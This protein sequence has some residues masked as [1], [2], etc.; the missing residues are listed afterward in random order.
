MT[1][2]GRRRLRFMDLRSM[3]PRAVQSA[4]LTALFSQQLPYVI[5]NFIFPSPASRVPDTVIKKDVQG[6]SYYECWL[7]MALPCLTEADNQFGPAIR[8]G[9]RFDFTLVFEQ[10]ILSIRPSVLML[11]FSAFRLLKLRSYTI[12]ISPSRLQRAKLVR[13]QSRTQI[14]D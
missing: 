10:S 5:A 11:L 4:A 9:H 14:N 12:K 8:C 2:K 13:L 6:S 3:G 7:A 1:F